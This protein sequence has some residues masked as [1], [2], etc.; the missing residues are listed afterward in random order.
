MID[1]VMSAA[2]TVVARV[3]GYEPLHQLN[4]AVHVGFGSLGLV[5]GMAQ[6]LT[7]KG[8]PVH[9]FVGRLFLAAFSVVVASAA[10]GV[11]L[12]QFNAFLAVITLLAGYAA[13]SGFRILTIRRDGLAAFD[14]MLSVAGLAAVGAFL[15]AIDRVDF[16]WNRTVIYSTLA[17]LALVAGYDLLRVA[18]PRRVFGTVWIY[19]HIY[20][21]TSAFSALSSAGLGTILPDHQPA[22]QL[23]PSIAGVAII[24]FFALRA[25]RNK[26]STN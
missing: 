17:A 23:G 18:F 15:V 4:V 24:L 22:S 6:F 5:L 13:V 9:R 25:R 11:A 3:S 8:G 10:I 1:S 21:M 16:P 20:K 12:F 26:P 19:E 14:V 7:K 2:E